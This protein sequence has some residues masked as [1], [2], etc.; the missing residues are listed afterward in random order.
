MTENKKAADAAEDS[1]AQARAKPLDGTKAQPA[2]KPVENKKEFDKNT[3]TPRVTPKADTSGGANLPKGGDDEKVSMTLGDLRAMID[4]KVAAAMFG[5]SQ[6]PVQDEDPAEIQK[7]EKY[8]NAANK[9]LRKFKLSDKA[10]KLRDATGKYVEAGQSGMFTDAI[11]KA[12]NKR[13]FFIIDLDKVTDD[14]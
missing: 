3:A 13:G 11:A 2:R 6:E 9:R 1:A 8:E 5:R 10:P 14:D 4:D 7:R 12:Y